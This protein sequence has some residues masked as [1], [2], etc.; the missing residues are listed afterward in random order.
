M[1]SGERRPSS[2][3]D[4]VAGDAGLI[5]VARR[6][7]SDKR[8][9]MA[10]LFCVYNP[11]NRSWRELPCPP[12]HFHDLFA[13]NSKCILTVNKAA[14][15]FNLV[16]VSK[17]NANNNDLHVGVYSS[18]SDSW[19]L[20]S[21]PNQPDYR[22]LNIASSS[23]RYSA[24]SFMH[25][26][27]YMRNFYLWNRLLMPITVPLN[28]LD[29]RDHPGGPAAGSW[30][31]CSRSSYP[32]SANS[33][34]G[35]WGSTWRKTCGQHPC[36]SK[37]SAAPFYPSDTATCPSTSIFS[38]PQERCLC[39]RECYMRWC[40]GRARRCPTPTRGPT[41][42]SEATGT[43]TRPRSFVNS[44]KS[45]SKASITTCGARVR[46]VRGVIE[47][48]GT[49]SVW[50]GWTGGRGLRPRSRMMLYLGRGRIA[51]WSTWFTRVLQIRSSFPTNPT[52][53]S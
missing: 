33:T 9:A 28:I 43:Q 26:Y 19:R 40:L 23:S 36:G 47:P 35:S 15:S 8:V 49:L 10:E 3:L 7:A 32:R 2:Y 6:W 46:G 50:F 38:K 25:V 22:I 53:C 13:Q 12:T 29:H 5:C 27:V 20:S 11:L 17:T 30:S 51:R 1:P 31:F 24:N 14:G 48:A 16:F 18:T 52:G 4:P 37:L 45:K 34:S 42:S 21:N 41:R 44:R 39:A